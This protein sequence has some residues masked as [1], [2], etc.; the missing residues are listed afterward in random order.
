[1]EPLC[2]TSVPKAMQRDTELINSAAAVRRWSFVGERVV[3]GLTLLCAVGIGHLGYSAFGPITFFYCVLGFFHVQLLFFNRRRE[4]AW[5]LCLG[6]PVLQA[7]SA[8]VRTY[9]GM[10]MVAITAD[11]CA[12]RIVGWSIKGAYLQMQPLSA[13]AKD[14]SCAAVVVTMTLRLAIIYRQTG[15]TSCWT[16]LMPCT[17]GALLIAGFLTQTWLHRI[18][19]FSSIAESLEW[20]I[21][22]G[23]EESEQLLDNQYDGTWHREP[24]QQQRLLEMAEP[25]P[26]ALSSWGYRTGGEESSM[27]AVCLGAP[28]THAHIPCGHRCVCEGCALGIASVQHAQGTGHLLKCP[29]CHMV[30]TQCVRIFGG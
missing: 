14:A 19:T 13:H 12:I 27:C 15:D 28:S 24:P 10:A 9:R 22:T 8:A 17:G 18:T 11:A 6:L 26:T 5:L 16:I 25:R 3:H 20:E 2:R 23:D 1:V 7:A 21:A 30:S 4:A 29:I